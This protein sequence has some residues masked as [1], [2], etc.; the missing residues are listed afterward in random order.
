M[1]E[2]PTTVR[3]D[4][5]SAASEAVSCARKLLTQE[6]AAAWQLPREA[7]AALA[8]HLLSAGASALAALDANQSLGR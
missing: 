6:G 4:L 8:A 5:E 2:K 1:A 3:D 7:A